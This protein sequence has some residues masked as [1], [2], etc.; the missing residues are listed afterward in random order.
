MLTCPCQ[1]ELICKTDKT[2][3][4]APTVTSSHDQEPHWYIVHSRPSAC[5]QH[6]LELMAFLCGAGLKRF[7]IVVSPLPWGSHASYGRL[8][9]KGNTCHENQ[10][11]RPQHQAPWEHTHCSSCGN[12][13]P[14][15]NAMVSMVHVLTNVTMN[16]KTT[17]HFQHCQQVA[18]WH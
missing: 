14:I 9:H 12:F 1:H 10:P 17:W 8:P 16:R 13:T 5:T 4:G 11:S 15:T 3:S 2:Q 7:L 18:L 6:P